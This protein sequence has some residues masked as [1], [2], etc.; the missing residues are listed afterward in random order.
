MGIVIACDLLPVRVTDSVAR[1][2]TNVEVVREL[3][4]FLKEHAAELRAKG[5]PVDDMV[6]DLERKVDDVLAALR[7]VDDVKAEDE[8]LTKKREHLQRRWTR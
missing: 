1:A 5:L 4:V 3:I 8:F 7:K 6:R 2:E